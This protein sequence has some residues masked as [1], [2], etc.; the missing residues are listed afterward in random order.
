ML[1][2]SQNSFLKHLTHAKRG[3]WL[4]V[5]LP[6]VTQRRVDLL[7]EV[8]R[9]LELILIEL[10]SFNDPLLP[11]RM[12]EYAL[13]GAQIYQRSPALYVLYVGSEPLNMPSELVTPYLSCHFNIIDIRNWDA[14]TL[15]QGKH[16]ADAVL[17]ILGRHSDR[18]ETIRRI[19]HRIAKMKVE[20]RNFA[21]S[22]LTILAGMRNLAG[23]V[24][25]EAKRMPIHYDI[26]DHETIG[27]VIRQERAEA[28]AE[29]KAEGKAQGKAEGLA[30]GKAEGLAE[31]EMAGRRQ[32][33]VSLLERLIVTRFGAISTITTRR[34]AK[35]ALPELE[36][37]AIR[38]VTAKN[39]DDLLRR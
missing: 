4:N 16:P 37:L 9:T 23:V 28:L 38:V 22:K 35:L 7:F 26:R 36:D 25:Q 21:Y 17:A 24:E 33:A 34:L 8:I 27:P 18:P 2:G 12:A 3:R 14:E 11:L 31:G 39:V 19:L 30:E 20:D 10:Q 15:L 13:L 6:R 29:G 5:E 32:E 1:A